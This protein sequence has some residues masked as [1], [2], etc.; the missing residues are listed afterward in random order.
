MTVRVKLFAAAREKAAADYA[1]VDL[2]S[3]ATI[4]Q[5]R[6]ALIER[7]PLLATIVAHSRLAM[8]SEFADDRMAII[9]AADLALIPPVSGG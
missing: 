7:I 2:P 5:L 3:G 1:E 4:G 8:N 6:S 9:A